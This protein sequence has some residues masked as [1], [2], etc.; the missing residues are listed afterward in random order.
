MP[1]STHN[2]P[3]GIFVDPLVGY[4]IDEDD[5][6]FHETQDYIRETAIALEV[7]S[8]RT[9]M[10][11]LRILLVGGSSRVSAFFIVVKRNQDAI[12]ATYTLAQ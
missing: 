1:T 12:D 10:S 6:R 2:A 4:V 8:K 3:S 5:C 7:G 9:I 11:Y